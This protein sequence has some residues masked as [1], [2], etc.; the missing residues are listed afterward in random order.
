MPEETPVTGRIA[1]QMLFIPR[2]PDVE[3]KQKRRDYRLF[4]IVRRDLTFFALP[5]SSLR[6]ST[7][8]HRSGGEI[9]FSPSSG[10][11]ILR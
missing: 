9:V 10:E 5:F 11:N 8:P 6:R 1:P 3:D 4:F 7:A 2:L